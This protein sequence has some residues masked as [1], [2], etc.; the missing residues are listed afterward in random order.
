MSSR[1]VRVRI[2][3][4]QRKREVNVNTTQLARIARNR[5]TSICPGEGGHVTD[6]PKS[7]ANRRSQQKITSEVISPGPFHPWNGAVG[8]VDNAARSFRVESGGGYRDPVAQASHVW[9]LKQGSSSAVR[10]SQVLSM[11]TVPRSSDLRA[12]T[13]GRWLH[14]AN[15]AKESEN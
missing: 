8:A 5:P 11:G 10:R 6:S 12:Q 9:G 15:P 4:I 2:D 13:A 7:A 1:T 14:R 3:T